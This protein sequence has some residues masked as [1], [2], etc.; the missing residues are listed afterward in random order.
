M[1]WFNVRV[2]SVIK[3]TGETVTFERPVLASDMHDAVA[4]YLEQASRPIYCRLHDEMPED[5][6]S[7][8]VGQ[9]GYY[10]PRPGKPVSVQAM[11]ESYCNGGMCVIPHGPVVELA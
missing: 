3:R 11:S 5:Q 1:N 9:M 2:S 7:A 8:P 6:R 4:R 10:T